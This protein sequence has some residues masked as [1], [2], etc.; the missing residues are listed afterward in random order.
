MRRHCSSSG[1]LVTG[2]TSR[3]GAVA[4]P[5][6]AQA[7]AS[8][9][10]KTIAGRTFGLNPLLSGAHQAGSHSHF[11]FIPS[12][13]K[14][15]WCDRAIPAYSAAGPS[16]RRHRRANMIGN[17][18]NAEAGNTPMSQTA[19]LRSLAASLVL[20]LSVVATAMAEPVFS[21]DTT[22]GKLPKS[23]VPLHYAIELTPDLESLKLAGVETVDIEV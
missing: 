15:P 4:R 13:C 2:S 6:C 3:A 18:R 21:F 20:L 19:A 8:A 7:G 12:A 9:M 22:P 11:T 17:P 23:V 1:W 10:K 14:K 16:S 5:S